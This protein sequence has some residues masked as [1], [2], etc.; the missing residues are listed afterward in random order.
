MLETTTVARR[1]LRG[2]IED[3]V[4]TCNLATG[5]VEDELEIH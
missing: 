4:V 3:G 2:G 5:R 1:S